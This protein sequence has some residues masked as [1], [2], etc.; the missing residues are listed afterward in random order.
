M[1]LSIYY[2][3]KIKTDAAGAR[4]LVRRLHRFVAKLP[5]DHVSEVEEYDPPDGRYAF[6]RGKADP[7]WKPGT[8]YLHRKRSDGRPEHVHVPPLHVVC[9]HANLRGAETASFGLASHPP[10]VIH[11]NEW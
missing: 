2:R 11:R 1:G 9:F 4:R 3:M 8:A 6:P 10:V 5:F 7:H